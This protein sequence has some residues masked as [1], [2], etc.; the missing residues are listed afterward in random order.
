MV[1][2]NTRS[3]LSFLS[4]SPTSAPLPFQPRRNLEVNTIKQAPQWP[5][6]KGIHLLQCISLIKQKSTTMKVSIPGTKLVLT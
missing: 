4:L 5:E 3:K 6:K 1:L 2:L